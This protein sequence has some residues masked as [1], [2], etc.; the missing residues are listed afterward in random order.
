M[1]R[2]LIVED[3]LPNRKLVSGILKRSGYEVAE[4][5]AAEPGLKMAEE[6]P[7]DLIVMDLQLPGMDGLTAIRRLKA[8]LKT[9]SIPVM[10]LTAFAMRGDEEKIREAGADAYMPKPISYKEF[11]AAVRG[12]LAEKDA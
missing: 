6:N 3:N 11:L 2:I 1:R 9:A 5:M 10:A 8:E 12:L 4:A 7:P